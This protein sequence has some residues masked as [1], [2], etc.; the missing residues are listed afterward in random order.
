MFAVEAKGVTWQRWLAPQRLVRFIR[1]RRPRGVS[2]GRDAVVLACKLVG[3]TRL[4]GIAAVLM[5]SV[6]PD[7]TVGTEF[8]LGD[9]VDEIVRNGLPGAPYE[10]VSATGAARIV[11]ARQLDGRWAQRLGRGFNG[12]VGLRPD[13]D[14]NTGKPGRAIQ[15]SARSQAGEPQALDDAG[16][17]VG[18]EVDEDRVVRW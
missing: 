3:S 5:P 13:A 16:V 4:A 11:D 7:S 12:I 14:T 18:E 2:Y 17:G 8:D 6:R 9:V 15:R 1:Q 10:P